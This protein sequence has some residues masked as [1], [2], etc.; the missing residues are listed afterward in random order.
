V[1]GI[2]FQ[3]EDLFLSEVGTD[4]LGGGEIATKGE[5]GAHVMAAYLL[6]D[7]AAEDIAGVT[8]SDFVG[9]R[10]FGFDEVV[11]EAARGI[12]PIGGDEGLGRAGVETATALSSVGLAGIHKGRKRQF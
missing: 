5:R 9:D 1:F 6:A 12:E 11:G 7:I 8:S 3:G 10:F 2:L 4:A